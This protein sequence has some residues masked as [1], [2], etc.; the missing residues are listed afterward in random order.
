MAKTDNDFS[1][2]VVSA[3]NKYVFVAAISI[4]ASSF[5]IKGDS[6]FLG[7][8]FE[9]L[10]ER[11]L[12][13][14]LFV[15]TLVLGINYALRIWD[16]FYVF[17]T[18][19]TRLQEANKKLEESKDKALNLT[20]VFSDTVISYE[21]SLKNSPYLCDDS[22]F[23]NMK[24]TLKNLRSIEVK[25]PMESI[26]TQSL[27]YD[28]LKEIIQELKEI[29]NNQNDIKHIAEKNLIEIKELK[30]K[31]INKITDNLVL[32]IFQKRIF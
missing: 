7:L 14:G 32:N 5:T 9:N 18:I 21:K 10:N 11:A 23:K 27:F 28:P 24:S 15:S 2:R 26:T 16:E 29:V 30:N 12:E 22:L 25:T 31:E 20:K 17:S 6:G 1:D 19:D 13:L 4:A 8:N 3:Y